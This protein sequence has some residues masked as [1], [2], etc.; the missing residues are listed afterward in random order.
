MS[1]SLDRLG[2]DR[3]HHHALNRT[4]CELQRVFDSASATQVD[5]TR[6]ELPPQDWLMEK[7]ASRNG[8]PAAVQRVP[9]ALFARASID[10]SLPSTRPRRLAISSS[11]VFLILA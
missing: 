1:G 10:E 3:Q 7:S 6:C 8:V 5:L 4:R 2:G 9:L 11:C